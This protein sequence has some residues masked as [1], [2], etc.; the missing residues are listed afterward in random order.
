[1]KG[2]PPAEGYSQDDLGDPEFEKNSLDG[3]SV[4]EARFFATAWQ[5]RGGA[6][7]CQRAAGTPTNRSCFPA[8]A[9]PDEERQAATSRSRRSEIAGPFGAKTSEESASRKKIFTCR[10]T[11]EAELEPCATKSSRASR[12]ARIGVR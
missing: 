6:G 9:N 1:M 12:A 4:F 8:G 11:T 3:D 7:A 5:P 2:T 10:P